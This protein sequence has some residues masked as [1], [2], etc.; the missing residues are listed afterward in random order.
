MNFGPWDPSVHDSLDALKRIQNGAKI[1]DDDIFMVDH[2]A[3]TGRF[4]GRDG[5]IY[6]TSLSSCTCFD[7]ETRQ[8]PCKHIYRLAESLG[9]PVRDDLPKFD[10]Y[11]AFLYDVEEDIDRLRERFQAGQ[12]TYDAFIKCADALHGSAA[13]A[14]RPRGRPR[15]EQ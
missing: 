10:P 14:K 7:F 12:L 8:L 1:K 3:Q 6:F 4:S 13:K 11:A 9:I 2:N 5:N 15:K